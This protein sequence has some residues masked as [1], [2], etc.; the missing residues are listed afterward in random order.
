M[1]WPTVQTLHL[2]LKW[3]QQVA[4]WCWGHGVER[5]PQG[6]FLRL[7]PELEV[8]AV[9]QL[10]GL[11]SLFFSPAESFG[12]SAQIGSGVVR[13]SPEVRLYKGSTRVPPRFHESSTRLC[14]GCGEKSTACCW[15]YHLSLFQFV[16]FGSSGA[17]AEIASPQGCFFPCRLMLGPQTARC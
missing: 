10:E 16:F 2:P 6:R 17:P 13:G 9:G 5:R 14:E 8:C 1:D 11:V 4:E 15:G 7:D 3:S 12:V